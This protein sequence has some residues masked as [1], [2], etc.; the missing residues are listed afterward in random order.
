[1]SNFNDYSSFFDAQIESSTATTPDEVELHQVHILINSSVIVFAT[2]TKTLTFYPSHVNFEK[3]KTIAKD[4]VFNSSFTS[5]E[6]EELLQLESIK[7]SLIAW[8]KGKLRIDSAQVTYNNEPVP[9]SV[10]HFLVDSFKSSDNFEEFVKPWEKFL[11][12]LSETQ[13]MEVYNNIHNFLMHNDLKLNEDGDIL[14]YK[15]VTS[16]FK[17]LYTKKID[18]SVGTVV[19]EDRRKISSNPEHTCSFGLHACSLNY[20]VESNYAPYGSNLVEIAVDVR[21]IVCVPTDYL[22]T[23]IRVCKYTV[24]KFLRVWNGK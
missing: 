22:G 15:A 11:T 6:I 20:L 21:D 18:N 19:T 16:D 9:S 24:T 8:G 2:P 5:Q 17:D 10:E 23:K 13:S 4:K 3:A 7:K 14:A 1:M 12:K